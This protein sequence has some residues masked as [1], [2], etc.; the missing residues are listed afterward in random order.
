MALAGRPPAQ[1]DAEK[2]KQKT[3]NKEGKMRAN[4]ERKKIWACTY[5]DAMFF[6]GGFLKGLKERKLWPP[7][8]VHYEVLPTLDN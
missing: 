3:G 8:S 2:G 1:A 5:L 7:L 4:L 6:S